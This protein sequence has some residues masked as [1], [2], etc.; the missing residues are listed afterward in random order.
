MRFLL[1]VTM[2]QLILISLQKQIRFLIL[3]HLLGGIKTLTVDSS[4]SR[5]MITGARGSIL[6]GGLVGR[7]GGT[8]SGSCSGGIRMALSSSVS[9]WLDTG[10]TATT[11]DADGSLL[12]QYFR[13]QNEQRLGQPNHSLT[14]AN[15]MSTADWLIVFQLL[16]PYHSR[17]AQ[18][19]CEP[20]RR[21]V[22][23]GDKITFKTL[24][25]ILY[26]LWLMDTS[27]Y[28]RS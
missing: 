20:T 6:G 15:D 1:V 8:S 7:G 23:H 24:N 10:W 28:S 14:R 22:L 2:W 18:Q 16:S 25:I 4:G 3:F 13:L 27:S 21:K 5:K 17:L 11:S 12:T 9:F 26:P 19:R